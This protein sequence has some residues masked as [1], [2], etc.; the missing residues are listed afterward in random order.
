MKRSTVIKASLLAVFT[1]AACGDASDGNGSPGGAGGSTGGA[2]AMPALTGGSGGM[3]MIASGGMMALPTGGTAGVMAPSGGM[4]GTMSGGAGGMTGGAGGA[5]GMMA[6]PD[7][8]MADPCDR[9]CLTELIT[10]YLDALIAN[11]ASSLPLAAEVRFTENGMELELTAGLWA[12]ARSLSGYR[13]DF[14]EV[15][16]GQTASFVRLEDDAGEVLLAVRLRVVDRA[17]TEVETIVARSGEATF[18]SP[19]NLTAA[20]PIYDA[21]LSAAARR[22]RDEVRNIVD[23]YFAGLEAGDG[24]DIPFGAGASR[25][26]NGVVTASG[27]SIS[28]LSAF[29][30]IDTIKRR[31]PL[32]D[33]E[34]GVAL[35]FALFEIP[36]GLTGS[37]TLHIAEL[38]KV[39]GG[40]IMKI[41][42]IMVNQPFG[43]TSGWE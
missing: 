4:G 3:V 39:E 19:Q 17:I 14:A 42:A 22:P 31:Y 5:G 27:A 11:D 1:L 21:E 37:R 25:N 6:E 29:S 41:H 16:A 12:V 30:Y 36:T 28:N 34:R 7:A 26:E 33:E 43:T 2:G 13:Q 18:F 10:A 38:F 40:E 35:P 32:V 24:S 20:D 9:A 15:A 23:S 8:A